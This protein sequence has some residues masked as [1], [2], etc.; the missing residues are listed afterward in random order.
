MFEMHLSI[1]DVVGNKQYVWITYAVLHIFVYLFMK[2]GN[3]AWSYGTV[4]GRDTCFE[5]RHCTGQFF[6][7]R[8]A[9][10]YL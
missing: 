3:P 10:V 2:V 8:V 9:S 1:R 7:G 6:V 4:L 5:E